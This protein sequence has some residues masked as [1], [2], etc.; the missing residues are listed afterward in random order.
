MAKNFQNWWP[1]RINIW[2]PHNFI[3]WLLIFIFLSACASSSRRLF[4]PLTPPL[5]FDY[6]AAQGK[7][8]PAEIKDLTL[9]R[10]LAL[11]LGNN[12]ELQAFSYVIRA[13][14]ARA[15]QAG[16]IA[17][18]EISVEMENIYG[19]G[20]FRNF[21]AAETTIQLSQ[22]VELGRKPAK[23][24]EVAL[25][26]GDLKNWEYETKRVEVL[27]QV[28]KAFIEVLSAQ[29]KLKITRELLNLTRQFRESV[30]ARVEAGK[31]SPVE[32]TR[33]DISLAFAE[34][35]MSQATKLLSAARQKLAATWGA[36]TPNFHQVVGNLY[37]VKEPPPLK[38]LV[39]YLER[40]PELAR[41]KTE[42]ALRQARLAL[43]KAG[44]IPDVVIS[45]GVRYFRETNNRAYVFNLS[46]PLPLFN[47]QQGTIMIARY[48]LEKTQIEE[49]AIRLQFQ[50]KL[51]ETYRLLEAYHHQVITLSQSVLPAAQKAFAAIKEGYQQGKFSFLDVLDAQRTLVEAR[52]QY[53]DSLGAYHQTVTEIERLINGPLTASQEIKK[54]KAP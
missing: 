48:Y 26:E 46:F 2:H 49:K 13:Q 24:K 40:H 22:L 33:A 54:E 32:L 41:W 45:G 30:A 8:T 20:A 16:L 51:T 7:L 47:R 1:P 14:E 34:V 9:R 42:R 4:Q 29:E 36:S 3:L 43:A 12:P 27:S 37:S 28:T 18:P 23:R 19:Q 17:N 50:T 21:E 15:L 31:V 38:G 10:A 25:I 53:L 52:I 11:A 35:Q 6:Q 5:G 44:V 39:N